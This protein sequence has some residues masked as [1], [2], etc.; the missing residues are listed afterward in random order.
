V[1]LTGA[2][3]FV[4]SAIARALLAAGYRVRVLVRASAVRTNLAGLDVEL[5]EGD[6]LDA[7]A[8]AHAIV[9]IR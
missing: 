1:L 6:M 5:A 2:T 7:E 8:V 3:G 4:G 9:G